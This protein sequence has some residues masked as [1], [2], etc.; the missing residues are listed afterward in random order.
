MVNYS[1]IIPHSNIPNLLSICIASI[2]ERE[3][4]E[5]I[6]V[7]NS[8]YSFELTACAPNRTNVHFFLSSPKR[9]AGGA[10]NEGI[11]H[12]QGKWLLFCDADDYFVPNAF[13]IFD[14][15]LQAEEDVIFFN[16]TS[17]SLDSF[18]KC[19]RHLFLSQNIDNYFVSLNSNNLRYHVNVPWGK[20]I[21]SSLVKDDNIFFDE[22]VVRND[23]M[24]SLKVG[25]AAKDIFVDKSVVYCVT[26][27]KESLT[28]TKTIDTVCCDFWVRSRAN[29]Y[30]HRYGLRRYYSVLHDLAVLRRNNVSEYL[31]CLFH[32]IVFGDI[33]IDLRVWLG[34]RIRKIS[35]YFFNVFSVI[36]F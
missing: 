13:S 3:D 25:I 12:A 9:G 28:Q 6:V 27:R 18:D 20:M 14:T 22:V 16:A 8:T 30:L 31:G 33:F 7:D 34:K 29:W 1:V 32:S 15:Y 5:V 21:K 17:V 2:P 35:R 26:E 23:V 10:R 36:I 11:L 4:I 19:D 24:F